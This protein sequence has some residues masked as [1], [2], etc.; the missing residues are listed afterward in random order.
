MN[1][2]RRSR[3]DYRPLP[4][5]EEALAQPRTPV[6]RAQIAR[7]R[8]QMFV[9]TPDQVKAGLDALA[10]E[11]QADEIMITSAIYDHGARRRSYELMA[12]VYG[13]SREESAA[14]AGENA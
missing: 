14:R 6:E 2:L 5:P 3:G 7:H 8:L 10:A 9:G 12:D 13:L 1:W 11:T 4:S